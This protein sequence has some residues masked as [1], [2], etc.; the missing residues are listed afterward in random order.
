MLDFI[1][2]ECRLFPPFLYPGLGKERPFFPPPPIRKGESF[3]SNPDLVPLFSIGFPHSLPQDSPMAPFHH[4]RKGKQ[5]P[6]FFCC[7]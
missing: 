4:L 2:P 1:I 6:F 7:T 5:P 3:L